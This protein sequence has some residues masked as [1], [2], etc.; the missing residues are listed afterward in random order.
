MQIADILPLTPLQHGLLF[1][2]GAAP[3]LS[4]DVYAVQFDI[5]V[6]GALDEDRL[7]DAV[8]RVAARHPNVLARFSEQFGQPVQIIP[9][10]PEV[11]W[12]Y[13]DLRDSHSDLDVEIEAICARERVAIRHLAD[14][15]VFRVALIR[16]APDQHR[17]VLTNHHIVLDGW[18]MPILLREIFASYYGWRLPPATPYRRFV[19]W[20]ADRDREA[21]LAAWREVLTG[22]ETPTLVGPP[23]RLELRSRGVS[24]HRLPKSMTQ[25][26]TEL[27]RSRHTT[28]NVVLQGA[29][30]LLLG[31]L[32][33]QHDVAFGTAV[34][35]RPAEVLGAESM[36]GLL[37]N[38]VPVRVNVTS[39]TTT[40]ELLDQLQSAHNRTLEHQHLALNEMHRIAGHDKLFDTL[41]VYENYPIDTAALSGDHELAITEFQTREYNHYSLTLQAVPGDELTLRVEFAADVF[42]DE[43]IQ[44]LIERFGRVLASMAADPTRRLS[45][46]DLLDAGEH[47][48][49]DQIGNTAVLTQPASPVSIPA[50]FAAQVA[51]T[52]EAVALTHRGRSITYRELDEAAN[53]LAHLLAANGAGP[54]RCVALLFNRSAEAIVAILAVLKAGA[55]YLPIDPKL[56]TARIGFM[57]QDAAPVAGVTT[58]EFA[59]RLTAHALPVVDVDDPRVETCPGTA[60]PAPAADDL[61]HIIYT[62]G[63]T[64]TPKGV[65]V[66]H[67]NV[68]RLFDGME[69][70]VQLAPEQVWT[71]T[72]SLVFD[73]SVWEI[74]GAL[75]HG[76]RLV[77]VPEDVARSPEDF[78][79]LLVTERVSVLSQT[80]S[81]VAALSPQGLESV[82]LMAAG[83]ACPPGVVDQWAPDRVMINGY[84]PTETTVYATISAP[85]RVGSSVVPIG[86]P[87]P[88]TALFVLDGWLRPVPRGEVGELY[89]AGR[90]VACGYVRRAGLTASRFVACPFVGS[91][92]PGQRM[93]RTGDLVRWGADGQLQYLGRIDEQVK[94]RGYRIEL[95]EIQAAL[96]ALDGVEH[97]AV[98]V[99]ED[100]PGDK[101]LVGY[102][103]G[104]TDSAE[105]RNALAQ[106]LPAY[107]V[108]TAVV[109]L[110]SLPLTVNGKL[111]KRALPA[112]EYQGIDTYRAPT[113]PVEEVLADIY[114]E[115]LGVERVGVDESFFELGGDSIL[116]M[117]VAARARA[118]G[119]QCRPR[120]IFVEQTVARLARVAR[121][122]T[123]DAEVIVEGL[124][125]IPATPI[126][127]WLARVDGP[128]DQFNQTVV[129]QA[130][131]EVA[132]A[133]VVTLLQALLDRHAMLRLRVDD[134]GAGNW[135]LT[136]PEAGSVDAATCLRTVDS[137]SSEALVEARS[138]LDPAAGVML[139]ALWVTS[140]SQL[141]LVAHHLAVDG[142]SWRVLLEDLNIAWAQRRGGQ[143]AEL[144]AGGTSF[145]RWASLLTEYAHNPDVVQQAQ[146]WR[147]VAAAPAV[148]PA[149]QPAIDTFATAGRIS[150]SL[151]EPTTRM[152]LGEVP[153]AFHAGVNDILLIAFG[154]ALAEFFAADG[155]PIG[156][157]VEGHGRHEEIAPDVD[158]SRT[159][160]WFT[161]KYPVALTVSGLDWA[162]V[163]AGEAAL[164][165][166]IKNAKEQLRALPDGLTYG[167]LRYL[168]AD[169]E[170]AGSDPTIG[171]NYL[172]RM[173]ASAAE[174]AGGTWRM[175]QDGL[176]ST[177][178]A[179]DIPM[180]LMHTLELNAA[181]VDGETGPQLHAN[182]T[183]APSALDDVQ[184]SRLS[185]LWFEALAGICAHV[186]AGGGG[187]TPS[188]I[189]PARLTQQQLDDLHQQHA[190]ADILPLSPLQ[191]GLLFHSE[192]AQ[193]TED[194][195]AVQL[196]IAING[197][198]DR[199]RLHEAVQTVANRH[200]HLSA[201][202]CSQFDEPVQIIPADPAV[203]WRYVELS[204]VDADITEQL[205]A[206]CAAERAAV[207]DL[208][209][210]PAFQGALLRTAEDRYRFVLTF[211]HIVVDGWSLP[212][213]LREI[214]AG[215]YGQP[216]PPAA[217]YRN[218]I[219][220]LTR[221]DHDAARVA[222]GEV[223][224][225]F[226]TPTMVGPPDQLLRGKR[227]VASFRVSAHT[228]RAVGDLARALHTTVSTVLQG[229][230]AQLLSSL[231]GQHDVA[232]GTAVSGRPD[233]V[234]GADSMVGLLI[235][236]VPVRAD[237]T[238][239]TTTA[240]LLEQLQSAYNR[241]LE[242]QHLA[243]NEI[244]RITGHDQLFDTMFVYENY[245][246]D[247]AALEADHELAIPEFA[248]REYNHYP[249][250]VQA[251]PGD[252]IGL[253]VEY[254]TDV[255][256]ARGI[257]ALID[258][259][260]RLL[261]EMTADPRRRLSSVDVLDPDEHAR[262]DEFGNRA[263]LAW[264]RAR[265]S[266]IVELFA[267]WAAETPDAVALVCGERSW[268][269]REL[270]L[271]ANQL[272]QLLAG[273]GAGPG[274][275]VAVLFNRSAEAVVAIL[276][277]LKTGAAYLPIDPS[278]PE[279]RI[280]FIVADAGPVAA[281]TTAGLADRLDGHGVAVIDV[282]D[283]A[284]DD[285]P[286]T[287]PRSPAPDDIAYVIYTSGTTGTPKG[288]A[289][290]HRNVTQL[291]ASPDEALP[292]VGV[293]AQCHTLAFDVS[294]WEIFGALL[295]G[296][297]LVV[298]SEEVT[299]SPESFQE[300]LA[301]EQVSV[302]TETPSAVSV[303]S[304]EKL[305]S[306]ALVVVGEACSAEVVDRWAPGR[307]MVNAYGPTET[308]MCVA[309]SAPLTPG[310]QAVPIGSPVAG[311]ALFVLDNWLRPVP[312][313][314]VGELYVAGDGV[315]TGYVRRL[316][317]TASRFV[318]CPFG[319][320]G[321]PG[322]RMYRTGDLVS[323][324]AD[325]QLD[326]LGRA[327][328][329][330]KIRGYR[331]ELGEV[332][333]S[334]AALEGVEQ[335]AVI[336][337]KDRPGDKR[338]VGYV[339]GSVDS[340]ELR[341]TLAERL[342]AYMV[343][344]AVVVLDALPLTVN[345]KLDTRALPAPEF[346]DT[347]RYRAPAN[348]T[349]EILAGIYAKVLGV[350]RVG[351]DDSFFDLGGDSLSAMRLVAAVNA[352]MDAQLSVRTLFE[353]RTVA[354]LAHQIG[355]DEG[356][357]E[358]LVPGERPD[359]VPLSFAQSRLWFLDQLQGPSPVYNMAHSLRLNGKLDA[360]ALAAALADVV[361]R[362]ESLRTIFPAPAGVPQQVVVPVEQADF[363]WQIVDATG[364]S[365]DRLH[366]AISE[367]ARHTF[368]LATEIPVRARL[369]R[370]GEEEHVLVA[371]VH[372]IA[373]DGVS[374][375]PLLRDLRAAYTSRCVGQAPDLAPLAAQYVDF[376]LWQ[377]AQ[378][379][380]L[381][382]PQSRITAQL[383]YWEQ[384]LA[385]MPDRLVLPTDRPYPAVADYSG[386]RV[387]VDWSPELQHRVARVAREHNATSF[388]VVQAA[389]VALLSK[390]STSHD[391]AVGFSIAGRRDPVLDELVGFFVNTLVLRADLGGDPSV[392]E[393]LAQVRARSLAAYEH[394]DVPF[395]MLVER[396]KPT[397]SLAH[398]PLVQV[399][400]AWQ[401]LPGQQ[402]GPA[403]LALGDVQITP[404]SLDTHT[405]RT[406]LAFHLG[407][408]WTEAGEPAGLG[409]DVEFRTDVFDAASI[410]LLIERLRRMLLAL[411]ADPAERLS[412][413]DVLDDAEHA[414]L[415]E[416]GNKAALTQPASES[417]SIP[418]SFAAQ[419]QR[420]PSS[421]A[422]S[423]DGRSLTYLE[424]DQAS[425][426][427]AH[428]LAGRGA[429]PG[430]RVALMLPRSVDAI[431]AILAVLKTGAAY[432]PLDP[433]HPDARIRFVIGDAAPAAVI[434]TADLRP[435][436]DGHDL[437]VVDVDDP[438]LGSQPDAALP[439]P[440]AEDIAYLI[441]TSGT[442]GTPKGVA[443]AHRNVTRLLQALDAQVPPGGVWSQ[444]HSLAFDF[445]VW[446]MFGALL[447]GGRLVV[448]PDEVVRSPEELYSLL[449][450]E[451]VTVLSQTPSAFY[452][453]QTVDAQHSWQDAAT[454]WENQV[455][456]WLGFSASQA[457]ESGGQLA[458][459]RVVFGGEAL[460]PQRLDSWLDNHPGIPFLINMYGITE[461]TVHASYRRIV[462]ADLDRTASPIGG[463]LADLGF[464]VL[465][466]WLRPVPVGVVGELYVAGAG[467]A[468]GYVGRA[469]LTATRFVA[470]PFGALG[471]RLYRTG[472]L[473]SWSAKGE[474]HYVGRADEQVKIRGYRIELGE[475]QAALATCSGAGEAAVIAREDRP[476]DK[477]L[478]GYITG[479]ASPDEVRAALGEQLPSYM[480][481]SAVVVLDA[482][483][484]TANGKLDK[485]AL[486]APEYQKDGHFRAPANLTEELLAGI[487]AQ[488]LGLERVGVDESFFELG[489]D[490]LSAMRVIAA[491][492][493][494]LDASV[495]VRALFEAP[496]VEQLAS[497]VG[498]GSGALEPVVAV[499]RPAVIPL[500]FA[501]N[502]LWFIDQL[503]G[504]S[505]IYNMVV[506]LRLQGSLDAEALRAA[507]SD[508]VGRHESLRTLFSA[509]DGVPR[510]V[511]V[512]AEQATVGWQLI[513]ATGWT[514]GRLTEAVEEAARY[515]FDL[516]AEIPLRAVLF[517]L[518]DEEH[519][520]VGVVH[521]I[522]ADGSSIAPLVADLGTAYAARR[523]GQTPIWADLPVQYVDYTLWQ[524]AQF[525]DLDNNDSP[526]AAQLAYWQDTLAGMPERLE[527]PTDRP[528]PQVASNRGASV[529]IDWP[530][531]LHQRVIQVA[532]E[533]NATSFMVVQAALSALLS[534][535]SSTTDVAVGFP[536]AGR[537]DPAL[538]ELIGFFVNTL[539][540]R[541]DLSDDPTVA[542]LL[543]QVRA[544]SLAAFEHQD[545]PFELLV[546]RLNPTRS[547]AH[548]PLIQVL[549]AW[550]N[551]AGPRNGRGTELPLGD[552]QATP[553]EAET[554]SAR[555]DLTFAISERWSDEGGPAG[556]GGAV[557]FRTDVFDA[558]SIETLI[559][560]F[561]RVLVAMTG[562]PARRLSSVDVLD[563]GEHARLD[564]IGQRAA[565]TGPAPAA[566]SIPALFTAQ[567]T[568]SPE[569]AAV[570]FEGRS[571]TYRELDKASNRLAHLLS[572]QGAGPGQCVALMLPRS[573][574]A[575][576]A[577]LAV[578]KTGAAYVPIDPAH[579]DTRI[580]VILADAAP[581]AVVTTAGIRSRLDAHDV[582]VVEV[583][584]P[585]IGSYPGTELPAPAADDF[586]YI[587]YTSG[588]TG[589]PKGVAV[590]HQTV[591]ALLESL[592]IELKLTGQ[593]WSQW[594]SF[595]FD[596]SVWEIFGA[597]LHG[598]RLVVVPESVVASPDDFRALLIREQVSVLNQT[599]SA[600]A[601]LSHEG[602]ESV[603]L[604][605]AGEACP[606]EVVDRWAPGRLM[607]N[608]YGPTETWYTSISAPLRAGS[609]VVP[610]GTPVPGAA[611]FVL[612]AWLRPVPPGVAGEL[613]VAGR[614]VASGYVGRSPLT[615]SRFVACPFGATG[616]R[617]YRTGDLVR[618][619]A[620]GQLQYLGRADDQV[621]IRGYRIELGEI[622][623]ALAGCAGVDQAAV[624]VREDRPGDKRLVGYVTGTAEPAEIRAVLGERLPGYMVPTAVVVL[625]ALPL[626]VNGKLDRRALPAP[627][628]TDTD[629]YRAPSGL[630][631]EVLAGIYAQVLG[632]ERVGVDDSFFE[633]GGDSLSAMR[634]VAAVNKS[635]DAG[636]SVRALF[637]TATVAELAPRIGEGDGLEPLVPVERPAVV[638][639][640]FAQ[641]RL[642]LLDQLQGPSAVY[643]LAVALQL[644][645]R[646]DAEALAA[647][648]VDVVTRHESLRTRFLAPGGIPEQLVMPVEDVE[649]GW[650]V[651][652]A[653]GWQQSQLEEAVGAVARR[654]FDLAAE[655]PLRAT[656]FKLGENEHVLVAV[657]HH[658]AADGWSIA[659]L[660]GDLSAAYAARCA[661]HAPDWAPLPVQYV[662]Y[663]LWQREQLGDLADPDSR[664]AAQL[665]YWRHA[666]ADM[667]ERVQLPTDR[668]YPQVAD[669]RGANVAVQ[670]PVQVQQAIARLA[671]AH[672]ATSFMVMQ[673]ALAVLLAKL[674]TSSDVAVGFPIAGRR[675]RALDELVGFFV[676]TLVLRVDVAGDP[677]VA[678]V[679]EQVR[680]RSLAA[681]EHQ[682]VPF[683]VLVER[684]NPT[685]SL[686][687]HPLVQVSLAWQNNAAG[688]LRLGDVEVT[689][690]PADTHT[691]RMDLT[692]SLGEQF[693]EAGEPG[694]IGGHVEFRTDVFDATSIEALVE[695]LQRILRLMTADPGRRLSSIDLLDEHEHARMESWGNRAA[696]TAPALPAASIPARFG[697]QV[698][699]TPEAVALTCQGRSWTYRQLEEAGNRWAY[700]LAARGVGPGQRVALL[701]ERSAEAAVAMLG[702][703]KT[704]A[705][706]VPID[707]AHPDARIGFVLADASPIAALTTESLAHRLAG[708]ELLVIDIAD[709]AVDAQPDT[710][711]PE[712]SPND[713]AYLIYTSG[714]TGVPKGV[715]TTHHNVTQLL[716][717]LG[718]YLPVAGVWTQCH[719]YGFDTS[720]WETWGPLLHGGR[721]VVVP[722]SVT[723]SSEDLHALLVEEQVNVLTQTPSAAAVLSPQGL[724][725]MALVVAGEACPPELVDRWAP[726]R[727]MINAFGPTETTMVVMLS[728]PLMPGSG[729]PPIGAP[730]PGAALFVLDGWL[731]P[732]PAGV[733]GELY[734]AGEG[735]ACGYIGRAA[736]TATRF[737]ACP[738]V[739]AGT[740][741]TRMYRTG[742]LVSW[743]RDGQL[744]YLGRADEQVK[745]RGYRIE[746]GEV[747]AALAGCDG[748]DQAVVIAREDRP[749]NKRL[750]GYVTET[751]GAAV[752]PNGVR[753]ALAERLPGYM[754]PT[755]VVVLA[756]LPL[757]VNGKLDTR[758]L[759][760]PEYSGTGQYR[761]P[762]NAVEE[763]LAGIYSEVLGV[764]RVGVDE[765]F[766]ELGGD[767]ILSMQVVARA[768]AAGVLC[769]PRDVF[770][771]QT[772]ARLARVAEVIDGATDVVDEG[773]GPV[774]AT[775][776]MR[777]LQGMQGPIDEF[778]QT[779]AV[780]APAGVSQSD[781]VALL[782][783]LVDRH[784][785][786][787]L[788]VEDDGAGGWV[789]TVPEPG[790]VDVRDYLR[791]VDVL[792][793]AELVEARS[794]LN[795]AAGVML[796]AVW[797]SAT[798]QLAL[799][800]HHLAV[801]GVSWRIL[802]ED[803]NIGWA[804]H[805]NGQ[806]ITL[807]SNGT[808]FARW[809]AQLA[810]YAHS[811][812]VVAQ[813]DI[814]RQVAA[815]S[816]ALP[817]VQ[818]ALDTFDTAG[819]LSV[820]L[821]VE[822]TQ[823]LLGE[824]PTA[825]HAGI[826]EILLIAFGLAAAEFC[827]IGDSS[828]VIDVEGHGRAEELSSNV[829][830][831]RTV[832]WFT[833]L[834]PV[835]LAVGGLDWGQVSTGDA[836]LGAVVKDAKEQLRGLP[837][838]VTYGLLRYLNPNVNLAGSDPVLGFNYLGRLGAAGETSDDAWRISPEGLA[839]TGAVTALPLPLA[840]TLE[841]NA[842]TADTD[843]GPQLHA[844]WTWAPSALNATQVERL[845]R[846]WFEALAGICAHVRAGGGGLTPSDI[847]PARLSQPQL[848]EICQR[849]AVADVLP[850]TPLQQG[851][852]FH[853]STAQ[854][855]GD[856]V[857]AVQLDLTVAG[858]LEP[859][860]LRD[861]VH[862]VVTRHPN[863]VAHFCAQY[864]EPVQLIPADPAVPWRY[865][866]LSAREVDVDEQMQRLCIAERAAVCDLADQPPFRVALARITAEQ[867]RLV[868]TNH[869]IVLDGWS[870]PILLQEIMA[871]YYGQRLPEPAPYRAFC[872]W[873]AERDLQAARNAW[874]A[875][876]AG[877][878]N[879]TMVAP[880]DRLGLGP[881]TIA[882]FR[883]PEQTTHALGE[884]ARSHQTTVST[885]LQAAWTLLL[886]S[887]TGKQDVA[888]GAVVSGRP[889]ELA[890]AESIAGLLINTVPV[891]ASLTPA[892]TTSDLLAQLQIMHSHT[893]EHQH[894][895]LAEIHRLTGHDK[896]FDTVFVYENY[897]VDSAALSSGHD[898]VITDLAA[899][900]YYHYPLAVQAQPGRELGLHVQFRTDIFTMAD[901]EALIEQLQR[902][903]L[904]MIDDPAQRLSST[905]LIPAIEDDH[906]DENADR[907][908]SSQAMTAKASASEYSGAAGEYCAPTT[909]LEWLLSDIFA[910]ALGVD[911][912]G[913]DESFFETG[914]DSLAAMRLI[915]A[916]N[917]A[918]DVQLGVTSLFNAPSVRSLSKQLADI[919][920][921]LE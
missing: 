573:A 909:P 124:G 148:L 713:L 752:D 144:P 814:W 559:R 600:A 28:V 921:S 701:L 498:A 252:E 480:V 823:M 874:A 870:M 733:V 298:V 907:R 759:P 511:V 43:R 509:V 558:A 294:V 313:G 826:H 738:F 358:P 664:I 584:D 223:F 265:G 98:I 785:T 675:D 31:S 247:T 24:E 660:V 789:L 730:V 136:V 82:A 751:P 205:E 715:A 204:A 694:G 309:I 169:V 508:V 901:I 123:G 347:D 198:L 88:G 803:L 624:V 485:Q 435:R 728:A 236:T 735:L 603:A 398:H 666:L 137:L 782:Q 637:E 116:S 211:H 461:T 96:A 414:R 602:L 659:P 363:G 56:P 446:E 245:P 481:P 83:E 833:A 451:Q 860:R 59:E 507:L 550:Q 688:E 73:F 622:Q 359:V 202:F 310:A 46:I 47:A 913:V 676:N 613:Y 146:T 291:L 303:L 122:T 717:S 569:A 566:V 468:Y 113:D 341:A 555:M 817:A 233:E 802:L 506:A 783:A 406:D 502:R 240:D 734:V 12:H 403:R 779:V 17:F 850:L 712:P 369:L 286:S 214:F 716:E 586:A 830:L 37:I 216:L 232:F 326:Y 276:A 658:I 60:L 262:L 611:F 504:P 747:Q 258:R 132:E 572:A 843:S 531:E 308:T 883:V 281:I 804:Q 23:D 411:T 497:R 606:V 45:T 640:S 893:Y 180:P 269:Y 356:G 703:L 10:D 41:L 384:A 711:L 7:R 311:A 646:L 636:L 454:A 625:D 845:S 388:M 251:I 515:T 492:N 130:P 524:R 429:G 19:T 426:R 695:R 4:D 855:D 549:L 765:S 895:G 6:R 412:S 329:Q 628:Y 104:T 809:S 302:L 536:I 386:A 797:A 494:S 90:G 835:A 394:Q 174:T 800:G 282:D 108:P 831:S 460:Q 585:R 163:T 30:A 417:G 683:E 176:S 556:I 917:A 466:D 401:T 407:E 34:S 274:Q 560:R 16:T 134:D 374:I 450:A 135:S 470:S 472:D 848:D 300:V 872:T 445:S 239:A 698:A 862:A 912:V 150:L 723:R 227:S 188:D 821:D 256:D 670:W 548:E 381:A 840:H 576:V 447:G 427:L 742:D 798:G 391:V 296:G 812:E 853:A 755:A 159:V 160:G 118:A 469:G 279:A 534:M 25:A 754:V 903:L 191:Q 551:F 787:R 170:L 422:I 268:T 780:Q 918:L 151:E 263:V 95:G 464:F 499:E 619:G 64:G 474:L 71:Q 119:L 2:A 467:L 138:R 153:T 819:R 655:I 541:V 15:P 293:W 503:Q 882:E 668:P 65:A 91:G 266:S 651:V 767:S 352:S 674:S 768:R 736:L 537:R 618:W 338:L 424:A 193:V 799:I 280:G 156:I 370:V 289:V 595:A 75:L 889:A 66:T 344:A 212:I 841:L 908:I 726:G 639:L 696:L 237:I 11:P 562:D 325:G 861:A 914:G 36:V 390:V 878:K 691:A 350:E 649:V 44:T 554:H 167:V 328:E 796:A 616:Q 362:H 378:L 219:S 175:S 218:F 267:A 213:L 484:L 635:L 822:T 297:R 806:P 259:L 228:T 904:T 324:R 838:G 465:D 583:D 444:C 887:M 452:A 828:I 244:H 532:S 476:G 690:M 22:F 571:M 594:H 316:G 430:Q 910:K 692:F 402:N 287:A 48:R 351:V 844:D 643:N 722:D 897:P 771:E 380:D 323:W 732:V 366:E 190:I 776:I 255:F 304:P 495:A 647:A 235:N 837:D 516:A 195:Y 665:A 409:G 563:E 919:A 448:V 667:P 648:L 127:H 881:R 876:L 579:P 342:P 836:T 567:V 772:V 653:T 425:N 750:V 229:A 710:A 630:A 762:S 288:V 790:T 387:L 673:A 731:R 686:N 884:L 820:S 392:S 320:A 629:R 92:A 849:H 478:V 529:V 530:A 510:Q 361:A 106:R 816:P 52:P 278:L 700:F 525:G 413:V 801:D 203:P 846:L 764:E 157:D 588:T 8:N 385:G 107:M 553:L 582:S 225:G 920:G 719:S 669:Y 373:A 763:V 459:Q 360:A 285:Q 533:H 192:G 714:T 520:L 114:A 271:A 142:V 100:R 254:D 336:A 86:L 718:A 383:A 215:Y 32:T 442:T 166:A 312:E 78:H 99:R 393:L 514:D 330:V 570:T 416:W 264:P 813:A 277:V 94:I 343:P 161:T 305:A 49:L 794:Q 905:G 605:V 890:G 519:V 61:A 493:K 257:Q 513:E 740:A 140:T 184:V 561:E 242:H 181:T 578:L 609:G 152:L 906:L 612:D 539:V 725:G 189:A 79:A 365:P 436:L 397:R 879:P 741:A 877:F 57:I 42:D 720:I 894:L 807:P 260:E 201:R 187:L 13:I 428:L 775:P 20:L 315:A 147:Q 818:P 871:G 885:V 456:R 93:Y 58:T 349:E 610:I 103:T 592:D 70:G 621:K 261:M 888:L 222:W 40:V 916:I 709:P 662:D 632:L 419:V 462:A 29:W 679:L 898:L 535:M 179:A 18:S 896:L 575:I 687:H 243:L 177:A 902:I 727:V 832:G 348:L 644:H 164:G 886:S 272:A 589:V 746:L 793:E 379:G 353:A 743:G 557:E 453:L 900:D 382:D 246:V 852:L 437:L 543:A 141:V 757:T 67:S 331:I 597:L 682:D 650:Q 748:V 627:E 440:A 80:P 121:A 183:W 143:P 608:G 880:P 149:A 477:R 410:E 777:W 162:Q 438:A 21:A 842:A 620:D 33:G 154:L 788:L 758:A 340:A 249:L 769:R 875:V 89:V 457:Q 631:E 745:V 721:V 194:V 63:T 449:I 306:M 756:A 200:P 599:P 206:V 81:A 139:G 171:F 431:V 684:L 72:S 231:T 55:A 617:M 601:A 26:L 868:L 220:W 615:A 564:A 744:R 368:D 552:V 345:G 487:Y 475:V 1:H 346:S 87:V 319:G 128:V 248:S 505:P 292:A 786:L 208:A 729:A 581:A 420:S 593:V 186:S 761:G 869:H 522:A 693:T 866:D 389:L 299:G 604:V 518:G 542:E 546:D 400:L 230:F 580:A 863:V 404:T 207:C 634:V 770:A 284:V 38:T 217:P 810:E 623:A 354:E 314:V 778:N 523:A 678:E 327:D 633:L 512:P 395:E 517:R 321:A 102:V 795:P 808:S 74:W 811:P 109:V 290:T 521:H 339:T 681:F 739:G 496:T 538:E 53:R 858:P 54:G 596:V 856:D 355:A 565:L 375:G 283:P 689:P 638:P 275:C 145:A 706:Y 434:T 221:R 657:V 111:D 168:N 527:L 433:A 839:L 471:A 115:I 590:T 671:G 873:L 815:A 69:V 117:Q 307:R 641:N 301:A 911:R 76:G 241:T 677:T 489:G 704:G 547:R 39:T 51:L 656:L 663:A 334:L 774:V 697:A 847:A 35:G 273:R 854:G 680:Q 27:A 209:H 491:V 443:V 482:L 490:S 724:D 396:L 915:A 333:A 672:G 626:T 661:G 399:L 85:L 318:A 827:D 829:D 568:R 332:Q 199:H 129:A 699:R 173:G 3:D 112:P 501:Q 337:R 792:S 859:L 864:D 645:G 857:Y 62:S 591:T 418:E 224:A 158:L 766:F 867:H 172:G 432:V 372:H 131:A 9:A 415:A 423:G 5:T 654:P 707:P 705:A 196:E 749:G 642:W 784:A 126:I 598:G 84:G 458:L 455:S 791:T 322:Q 178:A 614:G 250:T 545:V 702:V 479:S 753:A 439:S 892:T 101:R 367:T 865:V 577:L 652:D 781:V 737:V 50:L 824:V 376:T 486:P 773:V 851:L 125:K 473:V 463:P 528:Y 587:I 68:T 110:E 500:S 483:P 155:H 607:I 364:W 760:A 97:A 377:R 685:R 805:R 544:R 371:A 357:L 408:R 270:E 182:W 165:A 226:E 421:V 14:D 295:R 185:R 77:V 834:Y 441:Y 317:L 105:L 405:A 234:V 253:R 488:V 899:R 210:Q 825:F 526:I 574:E 238:S 891:R 197:P 133:D 335:A 708:H 120:D 540:L